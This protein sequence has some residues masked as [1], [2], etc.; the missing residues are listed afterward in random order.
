MESEPR[1]ASRS[2]LGCSSGDNLCIVREYEYEVIIVPVFMIFVFFIILGLIL[3]LRYRNHK[4]MEEINDGKDS[5]RGIQRPNT[6]E[7]IALREA[8]VEGVLSCK[9]PYLETFE[10]P[11]DRITGDLQKIR[12][13]TFGPIYKAQLLPKESEKQ[14][15]IVIAALRD[16]PSARDTQLFLDRIRFHA[17]LGKHPNIVDMLGC[18]TDQLPIYLI[19]ENVSEGDLLNFLWTCRRDVMAMDKIPFDITE[20]QIFSVAIQ[21]VNG[22]EYLH[23]KK[24]LHGDVAARNVLIHHDFT[25]KI[26]GLS[27]ASDIYNRSMILMHHK[28]P[29]KWQAPEHLMK[30][31]VTEKSDIWSLGILM[32]EMVTLGAPPYPDIPPRQILQFLQRGHRI[33]RP[34]TCGTT[35]Y[36]IMKS[37]WEWRE[38]DRPTYPD[39]KKRLEAGKKNAN[40]KIVLQVPEEVVPELYAQVAGLEESF[41]MDNFTIL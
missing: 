27:I 25:A 17:K 16:S 41:L 32:Y 13:G 19:M 29:L 28:I 20:K 15:T 23:Q 30:K 10:I 22:L 21:V 31:P 6:S 2:L 33:K 7:H 9:D 12:T 8:T 5:S 11:R 34:P 26:S 4:E 3:W 37:C 14:Q 39:L 36:N 24:L 40:D 35:L 18:C 1:P 38:T